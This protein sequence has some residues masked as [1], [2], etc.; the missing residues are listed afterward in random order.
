M[1]VKRVHKPKNKNFNTF[2]FS[3]DPNNLTLP[4]ALSSLQI[5]YPQFQPNEMLSKTLNTPSKWFDRFNQSTKN[6]NQTIQNM[7]KEHNRKL[8]S[9]SISSLSSAVIG[10]GQAPG[11]GPPMSDSMR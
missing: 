1:K 5:F 4:K 10:G 11:G 6:L 9:Y 8:R 3:E 7:H 2:N